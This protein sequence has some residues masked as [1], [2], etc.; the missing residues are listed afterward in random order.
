MDDS[1]FRIS[2]RVGRLAGDRRAVGLL[3][4]GAL[5][6]GG[7]GW[8]AENPQHNPWAP[9][10]LNDPPG[11]ATE[12]KLAALRD[13]VAECRAVLERSDIAHKVLDPLGEGACE[14]PDRTQLATYPLALAKT[15]LQASGMPGFAPGYDGLVGC[16]ADTVKHEGVR[17]LYRGIVPNL[18]KAVP[19]ISISYVVFE[20]VKS[21]LHGRG[22]SQE[23]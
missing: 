12:T 17:G 19:S 1:P 22:W 4:L 5:F 6:V 21:A 14:R 16:L 7:R 20:N 9:L 2:R 15:R 11:F 3:L 10:D 13:D 18:L 8:L 23:H